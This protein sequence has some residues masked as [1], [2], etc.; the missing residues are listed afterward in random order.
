VIV[1]SSHIEAIK[2]AAKAVRTTDRQPTDGLYLIQG[3]EGALWVGMTL[4]R[5]LGYHIPHNGGPDGRWWEDPTDDMWS[6]HYLDHRKVPDPDGGKPLP[7]EVTGLLGI[8]GDNQRAEFELT[9]HPAD[10]LATLVRALHTRTTAALR[11]TPSLTV[12]LPGV[13]WPGWRDGEGK[14]VDFPLPDGYSLGS[15]HVVPFKG[16][17]ITKIGPH[18]WGYREGPRWAVIAERKE[19]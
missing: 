14:Y 5:L 15:E 9:I 1:D 13:R 19:P 6:M 18:L 8:L 10:Q 12:E 2:W 16:K 4:W 17:T 7:S 11:S 3:P